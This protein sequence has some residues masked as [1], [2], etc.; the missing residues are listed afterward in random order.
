VKA[1]ETVTVDFSMRVGCIGIGLVDSGVPPPVDALLLADAVLHVRVAEEGR[2]RAIESG[3]S[4]VMASEAPATI[5]GVARVSSAEW[6]PGASILISSSEVRLRASDEYLAFLTYDNVDRR[7]TLGAYSA[8]VV[9]GR[10]R[11]QLDG[12][13]GLRDG[14][15]IDDAL[16][17]LGETYKR[18]SRYRRYEDVTSGAPLST[19][20]H[21][22]GW[23]LMGAL[24]LNRDVWT[25][26]VPFEF[27][28]TS[29]PSYILPRAGDLIR[30]KGDGP[31]IILNFGSQGEAL[32]NVSPSTRHGDRHVF[33]ETGTR[34]ESNVVYTVADIQVE[35]DE[36][37]GARLIWVRIVDSKR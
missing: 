35:R 36:I 7:F 17:R 20:T 1:G 3:D 13:L 24:E 34:V 33:D 30:L 29:R 11:S 2:D 5:L 25:D 15:P 18:H 16:K 32:R 19:L 28:V 14:S 9:G 22:T 26:G 4:C 6:R 8:Q 31:I 21:R 12:E 10:V 37:S 23:L 27:V